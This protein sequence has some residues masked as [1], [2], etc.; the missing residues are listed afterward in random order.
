MRSDE[1]TDKWEQWRKDSP[2]EEWS[3]LLGQLQTVL[4][5][6]RSMVVGVL[7]LLRME[8]NTVSLDGMSDD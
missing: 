8:I 6:Q 7:G 2:S 5:L 3:S 1:R 4:P